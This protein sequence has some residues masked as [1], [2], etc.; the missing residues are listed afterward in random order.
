VYGSK[1]IGR[2]PERGLSL[3]ELYVPSRNTGQG[4]CCY[5]EPNL[6]KKGRRRETEFA[7][8]WRGEGS[9]RVLVMAV[10]LETGR[11]SPG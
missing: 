2:G 6:I 1:G 3:L 5:G 9:E 11:S 10:R 7:Q 8:L 4:D